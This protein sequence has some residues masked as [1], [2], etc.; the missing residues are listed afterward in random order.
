MT[1]IFAQDPFFNKHQK[2]KCVLKGASY[3]ATFIG[4]KERKMRK[5]TAQALLS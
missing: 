2:E 1:H 3:C 5:V 4:R